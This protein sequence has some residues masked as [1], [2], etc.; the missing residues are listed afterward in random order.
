M[1]FSTF[2]FRGTPSQYGGQSKTGCPTKLE[3]AQQFRRSDP[4]PAAPGEQQSNH[5]GRQPI[6]STVERTLTGLRV[7]AHRRFPRNVTAGGL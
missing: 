6:P 2:M 3:A 7:D 1:S 4:T 5:A